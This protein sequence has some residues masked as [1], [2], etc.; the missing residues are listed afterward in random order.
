MRGGG[1]SMSVRFPG[2]KFV[3]DAKVGGS[4][5]D[6]GAYPGLLL[7]ESGSSVVGEVYE[8]G[9]ETL[10]ELDDFEASS[11][12]RRRQ[13]EVSLK[14]SGEACWTYEPDPEFHA[15]RTLIASG[16]WLEYA[17]AKTDR[18]GD[19]PPDEARSSS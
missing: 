3:G 6:L 18:H 2:A 7:D 10:D 13:V 17:R 15:P 14:A 5:Y 12:Y 9:E 11:H 16:D 8:V 1:R 19:P 4:L